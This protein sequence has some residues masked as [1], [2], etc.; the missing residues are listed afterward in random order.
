MYFEKRKLRIYKIDDIKELAQKLASF[1][2][3]CLCT[4]FLF[5]D[6]LFINDS[7]SED[8]AQEYAIVLPQKDAQMGLQI[9]SVT[10]GWIEDE[11]KRIQTILDMVKYKDE[12][13][14]APIHEPVKLNVDD[15]EKHSCRYCE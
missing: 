7:S 11:A 13:G 10:F 8:G 4:G 9:E 1:N 5:Q 2:T 14:E 3:Q 15:S 6:V 12:I